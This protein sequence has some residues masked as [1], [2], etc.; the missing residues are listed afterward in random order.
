MSQLNAFPLRVQLMVWMCLWLHNWSETALVLYLSASP[1]TQQFFSWTFFSCLCH[2]GQVE[3]AWQ[4][5]GKCHLP[6]QK[7]VICTS[8]LHWSRK[9]SQP[10]HNSAVIGVGGGGGILAMPLRNGE[11]GKQSCSA[12]ITSGRIIK[13]LMSN[14]L[15]AQGLFSGAT[16]WCVLMQLKISPCSNKMVGWHLFSQRNTTVHCCFLSV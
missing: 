9:E 6:S 8:H 16:S 13:L 7:Q 14:H 10:P 1:G 2:Q 3:S 15:L 11:D 12:P 4:I 5:W